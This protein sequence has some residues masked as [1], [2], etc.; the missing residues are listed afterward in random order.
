MK[1]DAGLAQQNFEV[2]R[3]SC[4][5]ETQRGPSPIELTEAKRDAAARERAGESAL[6]VWYA[7]SLQAASSSGAWLVALCQVALSAGGTGGVC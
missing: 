2:Q 4:P 5:T 7:V 1:C 6:Q 3:G